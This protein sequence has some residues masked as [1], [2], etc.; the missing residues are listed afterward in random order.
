MLSDRFRATWAAGGGL[1]T[2][3]AVYID[4]VRAASADRLNRDSQLTA[5]EM[6]NYTY[7]LQCADG[8]LYCGWT[9]HLEKR[10]EA[11]NAGKGAKYTKSRRPVILVYYEEYETKSEAL[12]REAAIKKLSR[13]EKLRM[14]RQFEECKTVI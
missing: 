14:I 5:G 11:H 8:T 2:S 9:N 12:R 7:L 13:Q 3:K 4:Q 6:M 1:Q 10:V